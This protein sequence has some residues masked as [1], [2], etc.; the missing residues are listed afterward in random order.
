[1]HTLESMSSDDPIH[2]AYGPHPRRQTK[3]GPTNSSS[4]QIRMETSFQLH[5]A[6]YI[7][8]ASGSGQQS[9]REDHS[10]LPCSRPQIPRHQSS[11]RNIPPENSSTCSSH[12]DH[13]EASLV[14]PRRVAANQKSELVCLASSQRLVSA[15]ISKVPCRR[16]K[17][18]LT[19]G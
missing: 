10:T 15:Q 1:M 4:P 17:G 13:Q 12:S 14:F 18:R 6:Q 7:T 9:T 19:E 11:N 2:R 16:T 8:D 3:Q 5:R